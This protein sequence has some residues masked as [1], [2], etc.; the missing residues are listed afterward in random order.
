MS[1]TETD[2]HGAESEGHVATAEAF[3]ARMEH[4][5]N[6]TGNMP[7]IL[8]NALVASGF[9]PDMCATAHPHDFLAGSPYPGLDDLPEAHPIALTLSGTDGVYR[10]NMLMG[11]LK[12]ALGPAAP[13]LN[14]AFSANAGVGYQEPVKFDITMAASEP[15]IK[16]P[17]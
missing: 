5:L 12:E 8:N 10:S 13:S 3:K 4:I 14:N 7:E 6:E 2:I 9:P 17:V 16:G 1:N 15:D 11:A